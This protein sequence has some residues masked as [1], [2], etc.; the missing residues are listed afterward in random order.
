MWCW[1][2][3]ASTAST[4]TANVPNLQVGGQVVNFLSHRGFP[5]PSPALLEKNGDRL[6]RAVERYA[7]VNGVPW[8]RFGITNAG[9]DGT[10]RLVKDAARVAFCFRSLDSQCGICQP[11]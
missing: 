7:R 2:W 4:S 11:V 1:T 3:R 8:V 10:N 9:T 6:R 5:I